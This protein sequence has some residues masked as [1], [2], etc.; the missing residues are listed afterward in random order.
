MT[1]NQVP[2]ERRPARPVT[3]EA[4]VTVLPTAPDVVDPQN[5]NP[6]PRKLAQRRG[7]LHKLAL[8]HAIITAV[9]FCVVVVPTALTSLYMVFIANDQYH[10]SASFSVRSI[11]SSAGADI[12][13]MF[14]PS[15]GSS[16]V[17]DSFVLLDYV[18][19]ERMVEALDKRFDLTKVYGRRGADFYYAMSP[20]LPIEE[21]LK[22]W[23]GMV[24]INFD[25]TSG[26]INLRVKAFEPGTAQKLT[27]F[28]AERSEALINELSRKA[29]ETVLAAAQTEVKLAEDRLSQMR[30]A[31]R[32]FRGSSQEADPV[33]TAKLASQLIASLDQQLVQ[34]NTDLS[35]ARTQMGD[36]S[37]RVRVLI[38]RINSLQKQ[39]DLERQRFGSGD[40][41]AGRVSDSANVAGR[42]YQY[43]TL[44]TEREFA[45]RA[46]TTAL[47]GLE[48]ARMD[49]NGQQR[50][51]ATFINPTVSELA[52]YPARITNILLV[53][54]GSLFFW[55]VLVLGYYNIRDRN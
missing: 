52:Q 29:R 5:L 24:D 2:R 32:N 30:E 49:A 6:R 21:K 38:S 11:Q 54:L 8:R 19:S 31:L 33:E 15:T 26:I 16:T 10:S 25:N 40:S 41:K 3:A 55:S 23:R 48:K 35:T 14:A 4:N 22:Y 34:L 45:E 13:G 46:Y 7:F 47:A 44:E 37:P 51:L 9:F 27:A 12:L 36:D 42:I 17:A 20:N 43:E 28:V 18:V 53:F 50:Y 39:I 1:T